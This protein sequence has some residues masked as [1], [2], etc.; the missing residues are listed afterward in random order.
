MNIRANLSK[1]LI[2]IAAAF[3]V[4]LTT[5]TTQASVCVLTADSHHKKH[6]SSCAACAQLFK[7]NPKLYA[8]RLKK[9]HIQA[10]QFGFS[11]KKIVVKQGDIVRLIATSRDV[12]HGIYIKDYGINVTVKK[13][14][15]RVIEFIA[16]KPGKFMIHCSVYCGHG[17]HKM[18]G[19]LVV[20]K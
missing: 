4:L 17:H 11:P 3:T 15:Q 20:K 18:H 5:I 6:S 16:N 10:Y 19:F 14:K 2:I 7:S 8:A 9:I 1:F 13:G 12:P